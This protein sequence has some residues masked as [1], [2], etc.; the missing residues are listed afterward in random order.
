M[1]FEIILFLMFLSQSSFAFIPE[2]YMDSEQLVLS[3]G[4]PFEA[5][6]V[7]T[8]D[9]HI[10]QMHRLPRKNP[11]G[12]PVLIL[13]G[14]LQASDYFLLDSR[15][16][17]LPFVLWDAGF[18]VWLGNNRGNKYSRRHL[19]LRPDDPR[20]WEFSMDEMGRLD[21]PAMVEHMLAA[22]RKKKINF[23]GHSQA[24]NVVISSVIVKGSEV[25]DRINKVSFISKPS[26]SI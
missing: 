5:S 13:H 8:E 24:N 9:G 16:Q 10:L 17:S 23:I 22:T 21:V 14:L 2:A 12:F 6:A 18:D 26:N 11:R 15:N 3:K 19:E 4:I 1:N 20:F 7:V 25:S